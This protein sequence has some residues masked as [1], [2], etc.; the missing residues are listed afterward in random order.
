MNNSQIRDMCYIALFAALT[1]VL[2]QVSI[3]LPGGVPLTLQ[4]L[5]VPLCGLILGPKRGGISVLV[6]ILIG[7]LGIPVFANFTGGIGVLFGM[8]GGF[9]ISFPVMAVA[10]GLGSSGSIRS[11]KLWTG[12]VA[13][14]L[15]NYAAGTVWF[16]VAA[17]ASLPAAVTACV[18]PFI[19]TAVMKILLSGFIGVLIRRR[20]V[21]ADL[22]EVM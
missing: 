2:A 10:A 7:A 15:I 19:P 20:L 3:P 22:I 1:A 5:A 17:H 21:A 4:T 9:I 14:A 11:I 16:M 12:L 6:Y 18:I 8:T 13:G